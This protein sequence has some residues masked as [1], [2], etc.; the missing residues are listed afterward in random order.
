[1]TNL[2]KLRTRTK[3]TLAILVGNI[4]SGKSTLCKQLSKHFL[5]I[6][7][8]SL[9]YMIGAGVYRFS[10]KTEPVI[11]EMNLACL[12]AAMLCRKDVVLDETNMS[13]RTRS[14]FINEAKRNNYRVIAIELPFLG[15]KESVDR[16][17]RDPHNQPDRKL[18]EHVWTMFYGMWDPPLKEEG[19]DAVI[20]L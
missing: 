19:L 14:G 16:R 17:M 8:D 4:G 18:W 5:I 1:M 3:P 11:R 10:D 2:S 7:R 6:S 9:R 20:K 15:M 12:R 13:A